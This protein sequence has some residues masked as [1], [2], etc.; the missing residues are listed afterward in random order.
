MHNPKFM[1]KVYK[2][3]PNTGTYNYYNDI[4][5]SMYCTHPIFGQSI[6]TN[7][8]DI[9]LLSNAFSNGTYMDK[10]PLASL[11]NQRV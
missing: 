3:V 10:V 9:L 11:S 1:D 6:G 7:D 2:K 5:E 4:L 8:Y